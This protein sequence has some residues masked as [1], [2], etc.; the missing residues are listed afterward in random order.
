MPDLRLAAIATHRFGLGP[1]PDELRIVAADPRGWVK[2]QL[3]PQHTLPAPIA[4]LP[5][6]ED[7]LLAFGRWLARRRL[8]GANGQRIEDRAERQG[9][10]QEDLQRLSI[11]ED[12][13]Q[14]FRE[15]V[16][17]AVGA[18]VE[19]AMT[20]ETPVHER[21]VHFWGNHFTVSTAKPGAIALPPSF[22]KDAIRPNVGGRFAN[23]LLASTKH[24]GM[25]V[26]L[27][28]WLS[29]GP[30]SQAAQ[31]PSRARR[32]PGGGRPTGINENLAREV[33]ELHTLGVNGGY[34]QTDVQALAAIITGWTYERPRL[35]DLVSDSVADRN[36]AQLFEFDENAHEP[37]PKTLLN[38]TYPQ[39]GVAQ[40]EAALNDLARHP[41]TAR[42]I[43]TKLTRHYI[44][45]APPSAAVARVERAFRESEGDLRVTMEALVDSSEAWETPFAKFKRPEE[46]AITL[47][48]L[49]NLRTIPPGAGIAALGAMGQRP[50]AAPGPDG[51]ADIAD[52]WLTAD[53]V[54]KR[55]EFA[56]AYSP[57]IA[58]AD[59]DPMSL[60]EACL[61]PLL[62]DETRTAVSRAE[63]PAQG[64]ALL[65]GAPEMQRR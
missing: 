38:R 63:S 53:L 4:A 33:L 2:A 48:R 17:R 22:E 24:P 52:A 42:F 16:V 9:V 43:A 14:N 31:N 12:F 57:R 27:D 56:Q 7:D 40:G 28:N 20:T 45:D 32:L 21:L 60:G 18:R 5:P 62:S 50:Y 19:A 41:S 65:C 29:V 25:I 54:W 37:G 61:G 55:L 59:L 3:G 1:R 11:E 23:K 47:L 10:T 35:R 64:L 51:W 44:A 49:A 34:T 8:N 36:G 39:T 46:Y 30:N 26:Y 58:R 13:V 15:R 6:A